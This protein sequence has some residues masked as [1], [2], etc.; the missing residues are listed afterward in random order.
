M[1]HLCAQCP[2]AASGTGEG[3][4]LPST[5]TDSPPASA[6]AS[7]SAA[8]DASASAIGQRKKLMAEKETLAKMNLAEDIKHA[9]VRDLD[10]QLAELP[11]DPSP[12]APPDIRYWH[13]QKAAKK[14]MAELG[15]ARD[16]S[17]AAATALEAAQAAARDA[18]LATQAAEQA[19]ARAEA[20]L[21][22]AKR[23][24]ASELPPGQATIHG[25]LEGLADTAK[26]FG[27]GNA[28]E[29]TTEEYETYCKEAAAA[30]RAPES[31][32]Q[33]MLTGFMQVLTKEIEHVRTQ[34]EAARP[35][36]PIAASKDP[37]QAS[38]DMEDNSAEAQAPKRMR[39]F[40]GGD[41]PEGVTVPPGLS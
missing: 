23:E 37:F 13:A 20:D 12:T 7:D 15:A 14:A 29:A 28:E 4:S 40:G 39:L 10:R 8:S 24:L 16:R 2:R 41:K 30:G 35:P 18:D 1:G 33:W 25:A 38:A 36:A 31:Q 27:A 34:V 6:A 26:K 17:K 22:A 21:S 19:Q 5:P 32:T 11:Q 3:G 9:A